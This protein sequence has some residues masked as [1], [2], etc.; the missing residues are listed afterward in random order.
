[1]FRHLLLSMFMV[2][3][4]GSALASD[5]LTDAMQKT[6]VPYRVALFKTNAN[7][8]EDSRQAVLQAQQGWS[9]LAAEYGANPPSPYAGDPALAASLDAVGKV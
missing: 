5:P 4:A 2:S 6:Y 9:R 7:A 1:M 8:Q 3:I